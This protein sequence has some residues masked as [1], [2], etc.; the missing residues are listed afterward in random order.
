V[1]NRHHRDPLFPRFACGFRPLTNAC[2]RA[3][4]QKR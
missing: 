4:I 2:N 3:C 1:R